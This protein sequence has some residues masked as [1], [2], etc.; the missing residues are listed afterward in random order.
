MLA[1]RQ[2]PD[3]G[4]SA[5]FMDTAEAGPSRNY[6]PATALER[7]PELDIPPT[8]RKR[9]TTSR[10]RSGTPAADRNYK[11][12]WEGCD[13]AYTKPSRLAEHELSHTGEVRRYPRLKHSSADADRSRDGTH[14]RTAIIHTSDII[15]YKRISERIFRKTTRH[16]R[17]RGRDVTNDSGQRPTYAVTRRFTTRQNITRSVQLVCSPEEP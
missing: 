14:A 5:L 4:V 3:I 7:E 17:A 1:V 12:Q 2:S 8:P 16:L 9:A 15:I 6:L 10:S 11:C 13:K